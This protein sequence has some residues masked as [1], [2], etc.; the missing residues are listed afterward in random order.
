MQLIQQLIC[1]AAI[2]S[3]ERVRTQ[4]KGFDSQIHHRAVEWFD[5][6]YA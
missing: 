2:K 3:D 4:Q 6:I 5:K 1:K